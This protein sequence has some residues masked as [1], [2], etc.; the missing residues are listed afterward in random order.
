MNLNRSEIKG[1]QVSVFGAGRSGLSVAKLLYEKGATVFVSEKQPVEDKI[2]AARFLM[3][4]GISTEFGKHSK[5]ALKADW[6][7]LS[8]GISISTPII[9]EAI[10][11]EI[12]VIGELEVASWFSKSPIIAITGSNGKSTTTA[13]LGD[14]F[15]IMGRPCVVAGNIGEPFSKHVYSTV[16]EGVV[17]LEVS[18]FQ[19]ET[20]NQFH[21]K[22]AVI[23]NL[24]EDHLD[25]HKTMDNYG[26]IKARIFENQIESDYLI[27]NSRDDQIVKLSEN[28]LSQKVF[29]G[30]EMDN[31]PCGFL[32]WGI[33]SIRFG[34]GEDIL[35]SQEEIKMLGEHNIMNCLAAALAAR[36]M[37]V[38]LE[39][40]R[41]AI[42][43]FPGLAHRMEVV[44]KHKLVTWINDSKA[45]NVN[46]VWYGLGSFSQPIV[47]IAGGRDK[48]SDFNILK[49]RVSEKVRGIVLLGEASQKMARVFKGLT[50]IVRVFSM[51]EA[52]NAASKMAKPGDVV[53]LSPACASFDMFQNFEER[54]N[55]FKSLVN[56]L[57]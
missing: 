33:L 41:T 36:L 2:N 1:T 7:V 17:V 21:P 46:S 52:V 3:K 43:N 54:G 39:P 20:I 10:V 53:L 19:L 32:H 24:S 18:S 56:E 34:Q 13:L 45:T 15:R 37:G 26:R 35:V 38:D 16:P 49:E 27:L 11:K 9:Q 50:K 14:I 22:V 55:R 40:I 44:R 12:P 48:D 25:R 8:P 4:M 42:R 6:I 51:R 5:Q 31:K 47:L 23:L 57:S 30:S 28:A 29:F